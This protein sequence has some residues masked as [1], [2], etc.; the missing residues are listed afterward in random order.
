MFAW[1]H[2]FGM[3][4]KPPVDRLAP[5]LRYHFR[6]IGKDEI[7]HPNECIAAYTALF[8]SDSG[9]PF[10]RDDIYI[11]IIKYS[12]GH[13]LKKKAESTVESVNS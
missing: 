5:S 2:Y 6:C 11:S 12:P 10:I 4:K 7:F 13:R 1:H 8:S 3:L 9:N